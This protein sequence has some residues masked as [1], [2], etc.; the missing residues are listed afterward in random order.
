MSDQI[1]LTMP[2]WKQWHKMW[3]L[4]NKTNLKN[5]RMKLLYLCVML[6]LK[7]ISVDSYT[8]FLKST[9][10]SNFAQVFLRN[11][12][13]RI[14]WQIEGFVS[15]GF[16]FRRNLMFFWLLN[17]WSIIMTFTKKCVTQHIVDIVEVGL[18][19]IWWKVHW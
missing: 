8:L 5:S 19:F 16:N 7:V 9:S 6:P 1:S 3:L 4:N 13:I 18:V 10:W 12:A 2:M 14:T 15:V 11:N 17:L